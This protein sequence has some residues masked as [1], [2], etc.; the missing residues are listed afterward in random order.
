VLA[1]DAKKAKVAEAAPVTTGSVQHNW[2]VLGGRTRIEALK[3]TGIS[4]ANATVT[5]VCH[6]GGCPFG[7]RSFRPSGG[8][9]NLAGPLRGRVLKSGANLAV[10]VVAPGTTGRYLSFDTRPKAIPALKTACSAPG[11]LSPIGCPGP[12]GPQGPQ[13][14]PGAAGAAG[15]NGSPGAPGAPGAAGAAGPSNIRFLSKTAAVTLSTTGGTNTTVA[16][17][18]NIPAGKY[19][20]QAEASLV[21]FSTPDYMRCELVV[22]TTVHGTTQSA[23]SSGTADFPVGHLT[24]SAAVD[25]S[26]P[27]NASLR[28]SHDTTGP[29][30]YAENVRIWAIKTGDLTIQTEP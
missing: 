3:V 21:N 25:L 22:G 26:A 20:I 2:T 12:A 9:A 19:L 11:S 30:P 28:C 6:G 13:G 29:T 7:S 23:G 10:I 5:V 4:P 8:T 18:T 16:T 24:T 14:A 15:S 17:M 1:H 27:T